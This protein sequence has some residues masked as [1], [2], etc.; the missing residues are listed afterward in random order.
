MTAQTTPIAAPAAPVKR[1]RRGDGQIAALVVGAMLTVFGLAGLV[2]GGGVLAVFGNDGTVNS[3]THSFSTP[4]SAL[5][6]EPAEV[7]DTRDIS[8]A[9]G[10]PRVRFTVDSQTP[11]KGVFVGVGPADQVDRYLAGAAIDEVDDIEV[12]PFELNSDRRPGTKRLTAPGAQTF[13]VAQN[14][15]R[16]SASLRWKVR[17]GDYRVV[18]MNADGS[19]RVNTEGEVALTVPNAPD[20]AWALLGGGFL[21]LVG[22]AAASVAGLRRPKQD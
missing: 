11:G 19:P 16:D 9:I 15:G 18:I 5:V 12:A 10:N 20:Y 8:D 6:S 13:W 2:A 7:R 17:D 1:R 21:L 3:G 22:G 14:E 4:T